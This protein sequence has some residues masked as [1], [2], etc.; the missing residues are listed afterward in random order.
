MKIILD[1]NIVMQ[2][3]K[4]KFF[5][6]EAVA[7]VVVQMHDGI[8]NCLWWHATEKSFF[9]MQFTMNLL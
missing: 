5:A 7:A 1:M 3:A 6:C 2:L 4:Q 9:G 8:S